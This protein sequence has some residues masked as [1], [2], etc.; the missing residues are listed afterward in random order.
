MAVLHGPSQPCCGTCPPSLLLILG[1]QCVQ[2]ASYLAIPAC[3]S[4]NQPQM[5]AVCVTLGGTC[6]CKRASW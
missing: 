1:S 3:E 4:V 6:Q 2:L 5:P